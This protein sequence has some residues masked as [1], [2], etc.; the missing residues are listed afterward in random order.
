MAFSTIPAMFLH[1][2]AMKRPENKPAFLRKE[3]ETYVGIGYD[4]L[5]R[6]VE[7][8]AAGLYDL[9]IRKG[10]MVG[11]VAENRLEWV[12]ADLA[13]TGTGIVDVPVFPTLTAKQEQYIFHHCNARAI[14]VSNQFQLSKILKIRDEL[15]DLRYIIVMNEE[16]QADGDTVLRFTDVEARGKKAFPNEQRHTWFIDQ[17]QSV[18]PD[19]L[20]TVIYTSGTTGEPKGVMLT[21]KNITTNMH[22]AL[23]YIPVEETDVILSYLPLCHSYERMAGYYSVFSSGA[24]IAFAE[25]IETVAENL[26][27]V[28]PTVMTSVPRLFERIRN[29]ILAAVE[30]DKPV[31]QKIF[32]WAMNV[33]KEYYKTLQ[34][35]RMST[36]LKIRHALADK[37]V[38]SAI[39]EKMG[40]KL[41]F[42]ASGGAALPLDLI[43]FF[44]SV[45]LPIIE[46]YGMT[47]AAPVIAVNSTIDICPGTV[48][49]P[50]A[51]VEVRIAQD[52]EILVRGENVM[53]GY[54]HDSAFTR[55]T[56]DAEGWLHTG[57]I[58]KFTKGGYLKITDRKKNIFVSSGGKNIAP[59]PVEETLAQSRFI[60]QIMLIGDRREY[61]TALIV[62]NAEALQELAREANIPADS[63]EE[64]VRRPEIIR[65]VQHDIDL[66]QRDF[67]KYEKVRKFALLPQPFS[68][69]SGEMTPT[70]KI[71]RH[72][73]AKNY[74]DV[75]EKLYADER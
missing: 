42:F 9:G 38:F 61:C 50:L 39:R 48:G 18:Q 32:H 54:L 55:E 4:E 31:K 43:E 17:C 71:K 24:T 1:V 69:E 40:G 62:P 75:I 63:V 56:I 49:K 10:D 27:E 65:A 47:E 16:M 23:A 57:D 29:K 36:G 45:G 64:L 34:G 25:S 74:V 68:V 6:R 73:V 58:G 11:I 3:G 53:K 19:D 5:L 20:L 30:K 51:N 70:L 21:N 41:R 72:V 15:P 12:I 37:L 44:L 28:H 59:Q 46:G 67:S 2:L 14:I 7:L 60:E 8:F 13:A 35:G 26:R 33:G 66:L 52:G 22:G